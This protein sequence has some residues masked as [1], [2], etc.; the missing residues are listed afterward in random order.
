MTDRELTARQVEAM[1]RL[2]NHHVPASD[3]Y[4]IRTTRRGAE[5]PVI[6][7][8]M[9]CTTVQFRW[10]GTNWDIYLR[11]GSEWVCACVCG[12]AQDAVNVM[13]DSTFLNTF[14]TG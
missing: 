4:R 7:A 9:R 3:F 6:E 12:D 14:Y 13:N 10:T 8:D 11:D 5:H 1:L 2:L